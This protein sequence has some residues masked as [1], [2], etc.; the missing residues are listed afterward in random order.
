[1]CHG[2]LDVSHAIIGAV[3]KEKY[4]NTAQWQ[5]LTRAESCTLANVKLNPH[6]FTM[7][8]ISNKAKIKVQDNLVAK[9]IFEITLTDGEP[10]KGIASSTLNNT[11]GLKNG[12]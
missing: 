10:G 9:Q 8:A 7:I 5:H 1:M 12:M 2:C 6:T 4:D 11:A 3:M